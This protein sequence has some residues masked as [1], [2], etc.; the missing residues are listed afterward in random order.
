MPLTEEIMHTQ[1]YEKVDAYNSLDYT[2]NP[3]KQE[4]FEETVNDI[5][6]IFFDL[7]RLHQKKNIC[8]ISIGFITVTSSRGV[9]V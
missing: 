9:L 7:K 4:K 5:Y 2:K 8:L 3:Y 1:F 6:K